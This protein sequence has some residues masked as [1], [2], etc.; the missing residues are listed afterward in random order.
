MKKLLLSILCL[1]GF[2]AANAAEVSVTF[3]EKGYANGQEVTTVALDDNITLLFDKG[4]NSNA[5]KYYNTGTAMRV[6]GGG[7]M[8]VQGASGV[9]ISKVTIATQSSNPAHA[10]SAVSAGTLTISTTESVIDGVDGESVMFTQGGTSGHIRMVSVKVEYTVGVA[11]KA[12]APVITPNGGE[13]SADTEISIESTTEGAKIYY[14]IDGTEPS[15]SSTLYTAPFKLSAAATVKAIAVAEGLENSAVV[16]AKFTFPFANIAEFIAA[17][18]AT[19]STIVGPVTVVAQSGSYLFLQDETDRII[20]FGSLSNSYNNGDQLSNIKGT[21]SLYN[22]LPEMNVVASSFGAATAGAAVE[23]EEITIE[24]V[25]IDN[26]LAYVKITG[27]T[28]P[29]SN[30]SVTITD[31]TGSMTMYNSAGIEIPTG[32]NMTII[33]FISCYKTT[34]QLLPVEITSASGLEVVKVP[35]ISPNGG[36]IAPTQEI[37]IACETE[38]ASIYYTLDGTEPTTSSTLYEGA[39][40]LTEECTVKAIAVAE[41][42]EA[43]AVVEAIFT[44]LD[45]NITSATFDFTAPTSL[46]PAQPELALGQQLAQVVNDVTFTSNGVSVVCARDSAA[47]DCRLWGGNSYIDL[48]TYKGSTITI[49][50]TNA[51]ITSI[52]FTGTKATPTQMTV[53][54]GKFAGNVWTAEE[55]K[56]VSSVVFSAIATTNIKTITVTFNSDPNGIEG[57]EVE[58]DATIE[59]YNLQGVKVNNPA[60]GI[61]I[62]VQGNKASKV[63]VK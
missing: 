45:E 9:T 47:T 36:A 5:C 18:N 56:T 19:A 1:V 12:N 38:G 8:T 16:E 39:F 63:Y 14:T 46:N 10:E 21:Y 55:G 11:T 23:P 13:I 26:L 59:Y 25:A 20:A 43:S 50:A 7:T 15:T 22:G 30:K 4:S 40:T 61:F 28:I 53:D 41:G 24:E 3:S 52:E 57:V 37:T 31:E 54:T 34:V 42:M 29:E 44:F 58:N 62:K 27:V 51:N 33:G 60:N 35:T 48:R 2:V 49:S 17:G 32:E 6:Y